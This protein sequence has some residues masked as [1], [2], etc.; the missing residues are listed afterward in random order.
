[1][2]YIFRNIPGSDYLIGVVWKHK[3]K[4]KVKINRKTRMVY[5]SFKLHRKEKRNGKKRSRTIRRE[6]L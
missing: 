1:M 6:A 2:R 5:V 4:Y 3:R